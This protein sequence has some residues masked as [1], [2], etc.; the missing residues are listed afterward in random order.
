MS[1][2]DGASVSYVN[3]CIKSFSTRVSTYLCPLRL[4]QY[5]YL[6]SML[7][8]C[9]FLVGRFIGFALGVFGVV[10]KSPRVG[11]GVMSMV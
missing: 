3:T 7:T 4:T 11:G 5:L 6:M 1:V 2:P 9:I 8:L 10:S